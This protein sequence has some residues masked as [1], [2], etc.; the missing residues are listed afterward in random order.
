MDFDPCLNQSR[1]AG[2]QHSSQHGPIGHVKDRLLPGL[3]G[4]YMGYMVLPV[5]EEVHS[6]HDAIEHRD[7]RQGP[8]SSEEWVGT[9]EDR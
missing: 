1:F 5:I 2:R 3:F 9:I 6:N 4:V 8:L 7:G